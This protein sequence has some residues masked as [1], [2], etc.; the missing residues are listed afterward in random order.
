MECGW[1]ED[2]A[3]QAEIHVTLTK[4]NVIEVVCALI[5]KAHGQG[6]LDILSEELL[7]LECKHAKMYHNQEV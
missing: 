2:S 4:A 3:R 5:N 7:R 1:D 6:R